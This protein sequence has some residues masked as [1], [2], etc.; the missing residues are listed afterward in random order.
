MTDN[1]THHHHEWRNPG[2]SPNVMFFS[3]RIWRGRERKRDKETERERDHFTNQT[4]PNYKTFKQ[5]YITY[6]QTQT[7]TQSKIQY[8][9][10]LNRYYTTTEYLSTVTL[11]RML[12]K[13]RLSEHSLAIETGRH[14]KTWLPA[15][16]TLCFHCS[17]SQPET[18]QHFLTKCEKCKHLNWYTHR[19]IL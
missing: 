9:L 18:K 5:D 7:K 14:R 6:W 2:G 11:K 19:F 4:Q 17:L 15:E 12:T 3:H 1:N 13:Y 10:T 8:Y 16:Q